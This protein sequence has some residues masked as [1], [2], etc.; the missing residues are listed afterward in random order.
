MAKSVSQLDKQCSLHDWLGVRA[1]LAFIYD[2]K[3]PRGQA[4]VT[5]DR[6]REFSAWL[7][8]EGWV[9][10]ESDGEKAQAKKGQWMICCGRRVT[11]RFAPDTELLSLRVLQSWP[12]GSPLFGG[13]VVTVLDAGKHPAL[14]RHAMRLLAL[15]DKLKWNDDY[16]RDMRTVFHW[17]N[18]MDYLM[19]MDHQRHLQSW[20]VALAVAL[21][22]AGRTI[23]VP[24][25]TDPRLARALQAIDTQA[26]GA[27]YPE[28]E[29]VRVSGLSIG[30]INRLC[31]Q[32][33]G[34]TTH[35][36][37]ERHRLK[38]ARLALRAGSQPI[39]QIAFGLGFLQLSHFSAWFKR[40]EG[41]SPRAYQAAQA[42]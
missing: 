9:E 19:F 14:E 38:R 34:F 20:Q 22:A 23:T 7:V 10:V 24:D 13:G 39:K 6:E 42:G 18:Q 41:M 35:Q 1:E 32:V 16:E 25:S 31:A 17:R 8:R 21:I 29:L 26:P 2:S 37:W 27:A 36:Y 3:I 33:Y 28:A 5:G 40:H 12:D 4:N 11:Q 30:R 15:T